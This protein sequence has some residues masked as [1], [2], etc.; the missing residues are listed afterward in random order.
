VERRVSGRVLNLFAGQTKL[1]CNE[2]RIDV[3]PT[4]IADMYIDAFA[5]VSGYVGALQNK[6]RDD[7]YNTIILDPPYSY[8]KSM[9]MYN[10]K[11][12][13]RF[14]AVKD[15]LPFM[16]TSNGAVITFGYQSVSMGKRRG[17]KQEEL[18]VMSHGGAIHDTLCIIERKI[19]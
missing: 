6:L 7:K 19:D 5:Y 4:M 14:N 8:R 10:G 1:N 12:M 15:L 13:S 17:F 18:L 2:F 16:L 3:D 9:E 11:I